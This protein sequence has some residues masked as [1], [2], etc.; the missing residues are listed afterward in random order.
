MMRY[1][2]M[3]RLVASFSMTLITPRVRLR[4]TAS[5]LSSQASHNSTPPRL[6]L[7]VSCRLIIARIRER[8][9]LSLVTNMS[10]PLPHISALSAD[11]PLYSLHHPSLM[12]TSRD[13]VACSIHFQFCAPYDLIAFSGSKSY[14]L[15]SKDC[16]SYRER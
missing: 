1:V 10:Q 14:T 13:R 2:F 5:N 9:S 6:V 15:L 12:P 7:L 11:V 16:R 3:A 8:Q 4:R